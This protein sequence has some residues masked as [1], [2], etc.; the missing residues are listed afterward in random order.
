[1]R[2]PSSADGCCH[3]GG[4]SDPKPHWLK[5]MQ[6][7]WQHLDGMQ[8]CDRLPRVPLGLDPHWGLGSS[9]QEFATLAASAWAAGHAIDFSSACDSRNPWLAADRTRSCRQWWDAG[10]PHRGLPTRA[11]AVL[12]ATG[13]VHQGAWPMYEAAERTTKAALGAWQPCGAAARILSIF[14]QKGVCSAEAR[15][16]TR[17]TQRCRG[18]SRRP[19]RRGLHRAQPHPARIGS[20]PTLRRALFDKRSQ[21][22]EFNVGRFAPAAARRTFDARTSKRRAARCS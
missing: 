18:S 11:R 15:A 21:F 19:S 1:M 4:M 17:R 10:R 8:R 16:P 20:R 13:V 7:L 14:A 6:L 5:Q 22:P 12:P 2:L 9:L 3:Q